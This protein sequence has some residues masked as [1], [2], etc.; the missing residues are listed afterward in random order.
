MIL[1]KLDAP[2]AKA[3]LFAGNDR[4]GDFFPSALVNGSHRRPRDFHLIGALFLAELERVDKPKRFVFV[5]RQFDGTDA[6][7]VGPEP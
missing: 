6:I 7:A 2:R 3:D 4:V 5:K 1:A